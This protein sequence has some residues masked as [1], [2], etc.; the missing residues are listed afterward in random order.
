MSVVSVTIPS[1]GKQSCTILGLGKPTGRERRAEFRPGYNGGNLR[2]EEATELGKILRN[3]HTVVHAALLGGWLFF[4]GGSLGVAQNP[5]QSPSP[6]FQLEMNIDRL[7][8]PVVVRDRLGHTINDLKKEDFEV[9]DN[10]KPRAISGFSMQRRGAVDPTQAAPSAPATNSEGTIPNRITVFLYDDMHLRFEDLAH[11]RAAGAAVLAGALSGTDMA[12]VVSVSG[13]VN[14]GLTRDRDKLQ[15]ALGQLSPHTMYRPDSTD[16]P[17][18]DYYEADQIENK[19]NPVAVQDAV[20]KYIN[21]HPAIASSSEAG[22][23]NSSNAEGLVAG[24]AQRALN[25]GRM[26]VLSTYAGIAAFIRRMAQLPGQRT[27]VLVSPGFLNIE[28]ESLDAESRIIDLAARSNVTFSALDAR[29]LYTTEMTASQRSPLLGGPSLEVN[30]EIQRSS[31][32]RSENVMADLADGTG[33]TFFH[34]SNDLEAGLKELTETP[35][36]VYMLELSVSDVKRNG[37]LHRLSVKVNRDGA[38]IAARRSYFM[39]KP[40]KAAK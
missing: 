20:R 36:C 22:N 28:Q 6:P 25:V 27:L 10:D 3:S 23:P 12:A 9:L 29:G 5:K 4:A 40:V 2:T 11:A 35:E 39:P 34:N 26:D 33:G 15:A 38:Q 14:S 17:Y 8:V 13:A 1:K 7:L 16:C 31:M 21:C 32:K 18:I 24:A 30:A 37:N 19:H